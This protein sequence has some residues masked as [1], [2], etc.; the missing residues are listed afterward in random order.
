MIIGET[1]YFLNTSVYR[2]ASSP[3]ALL[4]SFWRCDLQYLSI[5]MSFSMSAPKE[6]LSTIKKPHCLLK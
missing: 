6:V 5:H 1:Q 4:S 2:V 3:L